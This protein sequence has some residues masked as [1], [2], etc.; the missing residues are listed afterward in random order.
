V[1]DNVTTAVAEQSVVRLLTQRHG[2]KDFFVS[3]VDA[4]RQT[5]EKTTQTMTLLISS[6]ALI[7]L[8]VGGIG[9]MNIMLVSVTE[10]TQEIG[11]R[12]A[13]G[14]RRSDIMQQFLIEAVL[15]CLLGG[16]L[17]VALALGGGLALTLTGSNFKLIY[18][19]TAII[20]AFLCSTGIGVL[21]GFLPAR[22]A[23]R[24]DPVIALTRE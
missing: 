13:V 6:I 7:S 10:R 12:M 1:A 5:I 16:G 18:S 3:N 4:I 17:G 21:F 23:A 22:N 8:V 19:T 2:T 24:L 14:G 9:V 11:V 20:S 15:V